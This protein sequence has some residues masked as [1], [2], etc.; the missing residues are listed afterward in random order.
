MLYQ[1]HMLTSVTLAKGV[2]KVINAPFSIGFYGGV[3]LG[4]TLPDIDHPSSYIGR[5]LKPISKLVNKLC[6]HRGFTHSIP[7]T[8][9]VGALSLLPA[10]VLPLSFSAGLI[11]GYAAHILGDYF[12]K[13]GVPL[14]AP[15]SKKKYKA[16]ITYRTG[17]LSEV[18]IFVLTGI[19]F[20]YLLVTS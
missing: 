16:P 18:V 11:F 8:L 14:F 15:F 12:S 13:S 17:K 10:I 1:T 5:R 7:C 9:I 3:I 19:A 6:G 2:M 20:T 4:S